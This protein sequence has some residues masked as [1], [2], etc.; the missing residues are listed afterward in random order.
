MKKH[1]QYA[2]FSFKDWKLPKAKDEIS[3]S[4]TS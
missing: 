3:I 1:R 4:C 2:Q